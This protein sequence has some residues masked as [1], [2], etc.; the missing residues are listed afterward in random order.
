M[1]TID[2][3]FFLNL[4]KYYVSLL[5]QI[6][7]NQKKQIQNL[8]KN[9]FDSYLTSFYSEHRLLNFIATGDSS[10]LHKL[11][12]ETPLGIL[13]IPET[14][15]IRDE[16]NEC[17]LLMEKISWFTIQIGLDI[18][19]SLSLRNFYT[20]EIEKQERLVDVLI[21]RDSAIM[22]FKES[23]HKM[24]EKSY[25]SFINQI[26]QYIGLHIYD[27]N[28]VSNIEK[29]FYISNSHLRHLFKKEVGISIGNYIQKQKS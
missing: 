25:S 7:I 2:S 24:N 20:K 9:E 13:P 19:K 10:A 23:I 4:E 29:Y 27:T 28:I 21:I 8:S 17:I 18:K 6:I 16:K 15:S 26:I 5:Q 14:H 3:Y 22:Q 11:E 12:H 1:I